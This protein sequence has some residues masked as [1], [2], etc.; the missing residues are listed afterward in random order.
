MIVREVCC[1]VLGALA[2]FALSCVAIETLRDK[3][4]PAP[5]R[6]KTTIEDVV[7]S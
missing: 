1:V 6:E 2:L 7:V 4:A 5:V 3:D